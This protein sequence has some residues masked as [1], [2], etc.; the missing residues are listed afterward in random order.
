MI[1]LITPSALWTSL[2]ALEQHKATVG[3]ARCAISSILNGTDDRLI[4]VVG[5][6]SVHDPKAAL[7]YATWL[8]PLAV[9][10]SAD[11]VITM[12]CY[13]EKPRTTLGWKG[14]FYDPNMDGSS[15]MNDG[16]RRARELLLQVVALGLP[17]ATEF[18]DVITQGYISDLVSWGCIGA[19]T[20]ESQIHRELGSALP[21]PI[22]FK[23]ATDGSLQGCLDAVQV[24]KV[25]HHYVGVDRHGQS[26]L[27]RS[28]GNPDAHVVLR[29]STRGTNYDAVSVAEACAGLPPGRQHVIV[30]CSHG[31]AQKDYR[32]QPIVCEELSRQIEVSTNVC[33]VMVESFLVEGAQNVKAPMSSMVYGQSVTDPCVGWETT[34]TMLRRLSEAVRTRRGKEREKRKRGRHDT[35]LRQ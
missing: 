34:V 29:G 14:F 12:R 20:S 17:V 16:I 33:G 10:L 13:F 25:P 23:N 7:E 2:P 35:P 28:H 6:C 26:C 11:L 3:A 5:P 15:L 8:A 27:A 32:R 1:P 9:E 30:D 31:N 22:A 4:V 24:A 21:M 18:L 19:R